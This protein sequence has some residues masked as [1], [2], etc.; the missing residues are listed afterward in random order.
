MKVR[1]FFLMAL[2]ASMAL[3][4]CDKSENDVVPTDTQLKG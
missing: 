3:V 1:N 4:S 2:A